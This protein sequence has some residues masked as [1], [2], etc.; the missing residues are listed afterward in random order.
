M[1][2]DRNMAREKFMFRVLLFVL[3]K[4]FYPVPIVRV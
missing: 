4:T 2:K 1:Y 3:K